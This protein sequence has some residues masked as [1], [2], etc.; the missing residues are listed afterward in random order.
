MAPSGSRQARAN[1]V[2]VVIYSLAGGGAE[3]VAI[4]LCRYLRDQ[5]REVI[6]LTLDGDD[7]DVHAGPTGVRRERMEVRR[8]AYTPLQ[9]AW[10]FFNRIRSM[11][12]KIRDLEPDVVVSFMDLVNV[13]TVLCL[14]GTGIPVIVSERLHPACNPISRIW[15][16]ARRLVYPFANA[17]TVQT[18]D[19]A[20][21]FKQRTRVKH[22]VVIPN[23]A[24]LP[25][26]LVVEAGD[27]VAVPSRSLMLA[28]GRL[29]EQKGLDLL[30]D[31]FHRS[32]LAQAGWHLV[33]LGQGPQRSVLE[34]QAARLQLTDAVT[35]GGFVRVG[36]W[37]SRADIFVLSSRYEGFPNAL[38]EALQMQRA[39]VSFDCPSGPRDLIENDRNGLLVPPE[40]VAALSE[41]M[42][43]LAADPD[44]RRRLGA[45][46]AK[47]GEQLAPTLVYGKW[48]ALMDAVFAGRSGALRW[49]VRTNPQ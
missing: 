46:A 40:D 30:L 2:V 17:V 35:F 8:V 1:R 16:L 18:R 39:C 12:R 49:L 32:G 20:E 10:Y 23:A 44:L 47:V 4:D 29:T 33:I 43:R 38:V 34:Q 6:L 26:D 31:A 28:I 45:E 24:R 48:L 27:P 25:Q 3:R 37:L 36:P 42:K 21:W 7:P 22:A 19:G 41:A 13:W 11:R 9:T 15:K 14:F 5:H